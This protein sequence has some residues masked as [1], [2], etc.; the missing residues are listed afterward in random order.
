MQINETEA[1]SGSGKMNVITRV[2]FEKHMAESRSYSI[3]A[4]EHQV[5]TL[6]V[7]G[8]PNAGRSLSPSHVDLPRFAVQTAFL[9][10]TG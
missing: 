4:R 1:S 2:A 5:G 6:D 10:Q 7:L 8:P 3:Q 9:G